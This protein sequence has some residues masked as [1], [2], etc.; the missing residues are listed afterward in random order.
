MKEL[1][2]KEIKEIKMR[3]LSMISHGDKLSFYSAYLI[4]EAMGRISQILMAADIPIAEN[5]EY[6]ESVLGKEI[7]EFLMEE[8]SSVRKKFLTWDNSSQPT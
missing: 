7:V 5:Q 2:V 8:I 1:R 6:L 3:Y 4:G